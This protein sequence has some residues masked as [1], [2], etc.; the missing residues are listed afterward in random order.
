[1]SAKSTFDTANERSSHFLT[2]YDLLHNKRKRQART[3]WSENFK[4][5]MNWKKS[6][7]IIRI[8]GKDSML[9][10]KT[11][12]GLTYDRFDHTYVSELLRSSMVAAVSALDRYMHDLVLE[13]CW[14]LLSGPE[15][16]IPKE[17]RRLSI[18][19]IETKRAIDQ[20]KSDRKARPGHRIK[21]A[22]QVVLHEST[23][24]GP[25]A[26]EKCGKMLGISDFWGEVAGGMP[27][28]P[29]KGEIKDELSKI[30]RRRNQIV[31]EADLE[32]KIKSR[33]DSLRKITRAEAQN[34]IDFVK[35]LVVAIDA[36]AAN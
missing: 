28:N 20:V 29:A 3:D 10:V 26:I 23:F 24:Q 12:R 2:L 19:V 15:R 16:N 25:D 27:N 8:D 5:F 4:K 31:H 21:K 1:M 35:N 11:H 22:I 14:K 18:P 36:A 9:I 33:K 7:P 6:T 17:L 34:A 30:V 32:R 13:K